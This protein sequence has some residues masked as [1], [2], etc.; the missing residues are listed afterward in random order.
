MSRRRFWVVLG[1]LAVLGL[2]GWAAYRYHTTL[3]EHL[4]ARGRKALERGDVDEALRVAGR[5]EEHGHQATGLLLR[6]ESWLVVAQ[7]GGEGSQPSPR[8]ALQRALTVLGRVQS[9]EPAGL[10]AAVRAG[11]GLVRLGQL[12]E[13]AD[14]L[15]RVVQRQP[16]QRDA[17]RWL[18]AVYIDLSSPTEAIRHLTEWGRLDPS[19]GRPYRWI[20][21]FYKDYQNM[22][23]AIPAYREALARHLPA[24]LRG[25]V[26][27]ELAETLLDGRADYQGVLDL[28]QECTEGVANSPDL[29]LFRAE[30]L[31]GLG[32]RAE[33]EKLADEVLRT[34]PSYPRALRVRARM[35]T[36]TDQ[37]QQARPLLEK[38]VALRPLDLSARQHLLEV[39]QQ[40][41][42]EPAV[43]VHRQKYEE[44]RALSRRMSQLYLLARERPWDDGVRLEIARLCLKLNR[45]DEARTM[46]RA[47]LASN[48]GNLEARRL[49]D[50][51]PDKA[52][53]TR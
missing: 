48:P 8:Q 37:L 10:E 3:P 18:A 45:V 16:D 32:R 30:S 49:M 50:S 26:V 33:A 41:K 34:D 4:L 9:G 12:R 28:L 36:A 29:R 23:A 5:L 39:C 44:E 20:G 38:C 25:D 7:A 14:V 52:P 27:R 31:W 13:A 46:L 17:H 1:I 53:P 47:A 2:G 21:F 43:K 15:K 22:E 51:L 6:G 42:D 24:E 40:L 35:C 11:E 19:D